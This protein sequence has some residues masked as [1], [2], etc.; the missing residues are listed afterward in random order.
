MNSKYNILKY[1]S[2]NLSNIEDL[3]SIEE[4]LEISIKFKNEEIWIQKI[5]SITMR[6]PGND[7]DL[8]RGFLF[9]EKIIEKNNFIE[10]IESIGEYVGEYKLQNKIVATLNDSENVDIDKIKRNFLTNSSCGVCGKTSLDSL[11]IIKK[12][13]TLKSLPKISKEIIIK[14][15]ATLRD[16]QSE[17]S[18]TGGIH[19]SGLFS[20][21]GEIISL[22]EDVGR[23][24][25]LDK[26]IGHSLNNGLLDPPS[27]F[28]T[29]SGRLNFELVQK[30]LMTNIGILIGVGAPT[31]LAID[32][33]NKFDITLIGFVKEDSFNI[34]SNEN[35]VIIKN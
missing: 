2:N 13:K 6:T 33:A 18:K 5:I 32:L 14:S 30:V 17:F 8:V 23:H 3:V 21:N 29:C 34:Y 10:K 24:N 12:D 16:N 27:Q 4:P 26:V 1:K 15:P 11:E 22:R 25:A 31:S 20:S 35:R 7:E 28:I 19:A 9:N